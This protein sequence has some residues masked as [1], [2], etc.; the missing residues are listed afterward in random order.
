MM[1]TPWWKTV[2]LRDEI[3]SAS[4][5]IEDV[6]MSLFNAVHGVAGGGKVPYSDP[7]YY[8]E[9][10][11]PSRSL[12]GLMAQIAVRLG[13]VGGFEGAR[14]LWRLDQG[15]GGGK[16]HGLIGLWHLVTS[17]NTFADTDLG[18]LVFAEAEHIAGKG[19][20]ASDLGHPV[21][22]VLSCDNMTPG[23]GDKTLDGPADTLG[24]RFLWRLFDG[25]SKT[26]NEFR[27]HTSNKDML[28][29]ALARVGR[30]VLILVDEIMDYIRA[31]SS[32][33][34]DKLV[35]QD[36]A[37]L[38]ALLDTVNDVPNCAMVFVLISSERDN[39]VLTD[40][41]SH[42]RDELHDLLVRNGETESVTSANDFADIIRRRLFDGSPAK[43]VVAKTANAFR[44]AMGGKW[45]KDVFDRL[46]WAN[47]S[48]WSQ[49]VERA[50]PFH[51][52]LIDLAEQEWSLHTGFQRVRS[53]IQIFAAAVWEQ[54]KRANSDAWVPALIG[55]GDLPLSARDVREALL[56]SGL[57]EDQR[58]VSSYREIAGTEVVADDDQ[59]GT[60]RQL[61]VKRDP[62]PVYI[63]VNSR[64]AERTATALFVYSIGPR[65]QGRRGATEF[66]LKASSFVPAATYGIGDAEVVLAEL[67]SPDTGLA[68][69]EEIPGKGGQP[70]R[71]LLSTRQTLN[72]FIR[73]QRNAVSD[74]D[75][76]ADLADL[77]WDLANSGPFTAKVRV[78]SGDES[79]DKR[80]LIEILEAS[81]IDNARTNRLVI[82]DPRRF[83]LLNGGDQ[84]T[85][86]AIRAAMGIG[87]KKLPVGWASSAVFAVINGQRRAHARKLAMEHLARKRVA[88]IEA[89][90]ADE[91]LFEKAKAE[92]KDAEARLKKAIRDAYQHVLYLGEDADGNRAEQAIRFDK[93][94]PTSLDGSIVWAALAEADK[95]FGKGE[96]DAKALLHNLRATDWGRP[97]SEIRDGFWNTPRL[98]LLPDGDEDL[99]Q[100]LF[101]AINEGKARL[102]DKDGAPRKAISPSEI[103]LSSSG[104]RIAKPHEDVGPTTVV[105]PD[106]V[107]KK[108]PA[109]RLQL[110][111]IGLVP[112]GD[113]EGTV[114]TQFP[115]AGVSVEP[116]SS[117]MLKVA[118]DFGGATTAEHQVS[119]TVTTSL[120][121]GTRRDPLRLLFNALANAVDESASHVQ[122][123]V[124]ITLPTDAKD[125]VVAR[126]GAVT[127]HV[128]TTEL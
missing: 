111:N 77:A 56:N 44:A 92:V 17:P 114:A 35:V 123:T 93:E 43:E 45:G 121:D 97:I 70:S 119:I 83:S 67:R 81:G 57:I 8:G 94:G 91:E 122:M 103:N 64:A 65:P 128:S 71:L 18:R 80:S 73:A 86:E 5:A 60:A 110:E 52:A 16:S 84:E 22:V 90:R 66:E 53:T 40:L 4:G 124:K 74:A 68:A 82:L 49:R 30:P 69:L 46:P 29:A 104:L 26:W 79:T 19:N 112:V 88:D 127:P 14:A 10:T 102:V 113:G 24:E 62:P 3:V 23:K 12:V 39:M 21:C 7:R 42:C 75:R 13:A 48:E 101:Q 117:I 1:P 27:E 98:P 120:A 96:F 116:G 100:A 36:M 54:Q 50:Y 41:G 107:G 78:E 108:W 34:N 9:I 105:V 55:L 126:A 109:A 15:M 115:Q 99:R 61:D 85:R 118:G 59:R 2:R 11:F 63:D 38:R 89:V 106:V 87:P 20:I 31:A 25:A 6:Q 33:E 72:M 95:A 37:F 51:P 58:T 76:D 28:A 32:L 47:A 125:D